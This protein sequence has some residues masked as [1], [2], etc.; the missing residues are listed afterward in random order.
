MEGMTVIGIMTI[1]LVMVTQIF[2]VSQEVFVK[3]TARAENETGAVLA[4]RLISDMTRGSSA[5]ESSRTISGTAYT[6]S[7][8]VLVLKMPSINSSGNVIAS[9]YDYVAFYRDGTDATKIWSDTE[10]AAG[11]RRIPGKKLVTAGNLIFTFRYDDVDPT[12]A[13]RIQVYLVNRRTARNTT[14]TSRSW[15]AITLRNR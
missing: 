5:V 10:A 14:I 6:T 2:G 8:T 12:K 9:T 4:T 13:T 3:Q 1:V 15:T 7:S 11:S